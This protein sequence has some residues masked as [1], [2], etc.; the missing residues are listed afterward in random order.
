[1]SFGFLAFHVSSV[2][3]V[4]E[5]EDHLLAHLLGGG[6]AE[7]GEV[8][9]GLSGGLLG[10]GGRELVHDVEVEVEMVEERTR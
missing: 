9:V 1:M 4:G 10:R 7:L 6:E 2:T 3:L 8:K 5:P